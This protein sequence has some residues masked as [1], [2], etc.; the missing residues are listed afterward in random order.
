VSE[1]AATDT[2]V[3]LA[4][5]RGR[6]AVGIVRLSGPAVPRIA[7]A[8]LG[9]LPA[10]RKVHLA[11]FRAADG[12]VL[13]RGL[14]LYF[15]APH[16][17]TGEHVLELQGHGGPVVLDALIAR[18]LELGCRAA[19]AGEF[20]E[21]AFLNGK[22]D[23]A[24]AEA[25]ADLIEAG[26]AA[27]ARA[28]VRSMQGEF[29]ARIAHLQASLTALRTQVEAGIDFTEE[30]LDLPGRAG[31]ASSLARLLADFAPVS[32]AA[33]QGVLLREGITVVIA[34]RP[35]AGKSTLLNALS[36]DEVAIVTAAPGTTRDVLRARIQI[37]GLPVELIDTAGLR[38][39]PA[40]AAEEEGIR[41]ARREIARADLVLFLIDASAATDAAAPA[42]QGGD[43]LAG[44]P[45]SVPLT[46]VLNKIDC[47]SAE[48]PCDALTT[49]PPTLSVS[50]RTGAGLHALR[51]HILARVGYAPHETDAL[52]AR[53]RHLDALARAR[54][55][56]E[57]AAQVLASGSTLDVL[58]EELRL[59]QR[60]L[61]E[62]TGEFT[63]D[64]LLG[65]IFASFCIGK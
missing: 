6:G 16:S 32:A 25:I 27:A 12:E 41:R 10:A 38:A 49:T 33:H 9:E 56:V 24:E 3:A 50:A 35:N 57:R 52:A 43:E 8:L 29:S 36:G 15:P 59:A 47:L 21:R 1:P 61:G 63:P 55:A 64:D 2:I 42:G 51:A 58:A 65:A 53:R 54:A 28:A 20:S 37:E 60:A 18:A 62:I 14:A 46:R 4:S 31:L 17:F 44:I 34:G 13:D 30:D 40:D 45:A 22:M 23:I 11:A 5:A 48:P 7:R 19:R 39:A 26:S